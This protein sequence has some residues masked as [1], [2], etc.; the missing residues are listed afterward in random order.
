MR[1]AAFP[2]DVSIWILLE[3]LG[4]DEYSTQ[5]EVKK[6]PIFDGIFFPGG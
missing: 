4:I 1:V 3:V 2:A 6:A 5:E